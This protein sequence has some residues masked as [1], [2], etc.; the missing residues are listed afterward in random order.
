MCWFWNSSHSENKEYRKTVETQPNVDHDNETRF[1]KFCS[2]T[3]QVR[4][5][6]Y[7][8]CCCLMLLPVLFLLLLLLT[9]FKLN[10]VGFR[11]FVSF[12]RI[13]IACMRCS[14]SPFCALCAMRSMHIWWVK[15]TSNMIY[16]QMN[17]P[18]IPYQS[19]HHKHKF[20]YSGTHVCIRSAWH[21]VLYE[22]W[23][24]CC[25]CCYCC[26]CCCCCC[27]RSESQTKRKINTQHIARTR[28]YT[29]LY[30]CIECCQQYLHC[31]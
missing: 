29:V 17:H 31:T 30:S 25:C 9:L 2:H 20:V 22:I 28:I 23:F 19:I 12:W 6:L 24:C 1:R 10:Y 7:I 14:H 3:I 15:Q 5:F 26:C 8:F 4:Y 18:Y 11:I 21:T 16:D 27:G 13:D